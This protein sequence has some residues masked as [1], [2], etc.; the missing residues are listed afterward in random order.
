MFKKAFDAFLKHKKKLKVISIASCDEKGRPNSAP[1]MLV[2]VVEPNVVYFLDYKFTQTY[3]NM[4]VNPRLSISFMDDDAFTGYRLTG[5]SELLE[6]GKEYEAAGK[7]WGKRL[8]SYEADRIIKR[9]TGCY[10]TKE[11]ENTLPKNFVMVK[12]T[13]AEASIVKSDRVLRAQHVRSEA[14][15]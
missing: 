9:V 12:L 5:S 4:Q 11:A 3:S 6:S 15:E 7:S 13:A 14:K 10:S 1:K 2:D 8:I